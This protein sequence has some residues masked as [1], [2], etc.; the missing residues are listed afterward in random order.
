M[1]PTTSYQLAKARMAELQAEG[2][3]NRLAGQSKRHRADR[4]QQWNA[5]RALAA[6]GLLSI[7]LGRRIGQ[8]APR[9]ESADCN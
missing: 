7:R 8:F 9:S 3:A 1:D 6:L 2:E 4:R 5:T